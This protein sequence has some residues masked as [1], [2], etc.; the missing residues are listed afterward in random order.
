MKRLVLASQ[1][2]RRK[3]LLNQIGVSFETYPSDVDEKMTGNM[4]PE[5][6]AGSLS[7]RKA[8]GAREQLLSKGYTSFVVLAADT[9]V[10]LE[11]MI[12]GK[13][14]DENEAFKMLKELSGKWHQV[15]TG[16]T[17]IDG[18]DGKKITR[19][20]KTR[21]KI[22]DLTSNEI[23]RYIETQEPL[24]KAGAYGIQGIGALLVERIDGC[25]Y[26]VVGLPLNSVS[27][28]LPQFGIKTI[29]S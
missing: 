10:V 11:G 22:R 1:S 6:F 16:V 9:V 8:I 12:L 27:L 14:E 3:M 25:Y 26:N 5:D 18:D 28:M 21:V 24:D 2:P 4:E 17:V 19:V 23:K 29:L 7:E 13:P 20:E 15:M